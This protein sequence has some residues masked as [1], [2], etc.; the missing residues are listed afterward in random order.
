MSIQMS[1]VRDVMAREIK[2][3]DQRPDLYDTLNNNND[4]SIEWLAD[5]SKWVCG[6]RAAPARSRWR[7]SGQSGVAVGVVDEPGRSRRAWSTTG[8]SRRWSRVSSRGW[9]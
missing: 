7:G 9:C 2:L 3:A 6:S 4:T 1:Q 8:W 5:G